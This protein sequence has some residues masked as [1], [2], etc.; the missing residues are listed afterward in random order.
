MAA[1]ET[2]QEQRPKCISNH[3]GFAAREYLEMED[4]V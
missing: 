3:T 1:E 2:L 4:Q